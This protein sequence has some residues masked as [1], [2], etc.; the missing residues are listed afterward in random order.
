MASI[1]FVLVFAIEFCRDS[2]TSIG[3][4]P[5]ARSSSDYKTIGD[6]PIPVG[7]TRMPVVNGSFAAWLRR[8][9]LRKDSRVYLYNGRLKENQSAQFAVLDVVISKGDL[10]QCADAIMR[11]RAEYFFHRHQ[12][13]SIRFKATNRTQFS[14]SNWLRGERYVSRGNGPVAIRTIPSV[15]DK[16][17]QLELFLEIVFAYCGT[18][19]LQQETHAVQLRDLQIGDMFVKGGSPGHAMI[20]IDGGIDQFGRKVF[21]L[22]QSYMP[23]QDI[24]IV[25]NPLFQKLSPWFIVGSSSTI[26]TPEWTFDRNQLRRW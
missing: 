4:P 25:K 23:A 2:K 21:M 3:S 26:S 17:V 7:F 5:T 8:V 11:L 1:S 24:H 16:R 18:L 14:F 10:Q 12:I 13:D 6:I 20:V 15:E 9:K 22:A 19:S